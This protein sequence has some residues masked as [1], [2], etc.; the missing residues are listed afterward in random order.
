V[1]AGAIDILLKQFHS[2]NRGVPDQEVLKHVVSTLSNISSYPQLLQVLI[3]T[4]QAVEI[5]FQEF[6]RF[7]SAG[8]NTYATIF[9]SA[10]I[11]VQC[12]LFC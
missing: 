2:L 8:N 11:S 3:D 4:P 10:L 12:R 7:V 9:L 1:S 6:L 5:V